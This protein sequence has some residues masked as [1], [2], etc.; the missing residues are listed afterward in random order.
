VD[1][2]IKISD[3][4]INRS[5]METM[6]NNCN[7]TSGIGKVI[8]LLL[9]I[10]SLLL[11]GNESYA[12]VSSN[13]VNASVTPGE[14]LRA[15]GSVNFTP[16]TFSV[17]APGGVST[18]EWTN[19]PINV[20]LTYTLQSTDGV[21]YKLLGATAYRAIID[22]GVT[23]L[24]FQV[25]S[26]SGVQ[27]TLT[28][29]LN[30][31][32]D[33]APAVS[34][35][36]STPLL[37]H[38]GQQ[39]QVGVQLNDAG[40]N[41]LSLRILLAANGVPAEQG[42]VLGGKNW[43]R[44]LQGQGGE[45]YIDGFDQI[46]GRIDKAAFALKL[47]L[48]ID[49]TITPGDYQLTIQAKDGKGNVMLSA[50]RATTIQGP[51]VPPTL[52][53]S[54]PTY[55]IPA[56]NVYP[57]HYQVSHLEKLAR[58]EF[59][60]VGTSGNPVTQVVT[61]ADNVYQITD[62]AYLT[63][64]AGA[65]VG[66]SVNINATV[67]D[68][69]G[70]HSATLASVTVG[71]WGE[72][73]VIVSNTASVDVDESMNFANVTLTSGSVLRHVDGNIRFNTLSIE[74]GARFESAADTLGIN[75]TLTVDGELYTA[76][77]YS[78]ADYV[79]NVIRSGAHGGNR[80]SYYAYGDFLQPQFPGIYTNNSSYIANNLHISATDISINGV[81]RTGGATGAF[82]AVLEIDSSNLTLNGA[83]ST[84]AASNASA[85]SI[86][87]N[88]SNITGSGSITADGSNG[89]N[90][91]AG[92][93]IA[94]RYDSYAG[95]N[96]PIE[97]GLTLHA[98]PGTTTSAS[99]SAGAGTVYL[100]RSDQL[101][102]ELSIDNGGRDGGV[103]SLRAIGRGTIEAVEPLVGKVDE[104]RIT[105]NHDFILP[106]PRSWDLGVKG[107]RVSLNA[108][109]PAAPLYSVIDT[110][111]EAGAINIEATRT[112]A[113]A[114]T[115]GSIQTHYINIATDQTLEFEIT[116]ANFD[117]RVHLFRDDGALD[118]TDWLAENSDNGTGTNAYLRRH[119]QA[120][121]YLLVVGPQS[122]SRYVA[123]SDTTPGWMPACDNCSYTLRIRKATTHSLLVR[124]SSD[125]SGNIGNDLIGVIRLDKFSAT[126]G[127]LVSSRGRI[128][129]DAFDLT[130][131]ASV[132]QIAEL[133]SSNVNNIGDVTFTDQSRVFVGDVVAN[134]LV[135]AAANLKIYGNLNVAGDL[136]IQN[137]TN[138]KVTQLAQDA[139]QVTGNTLLQD[140]ELSL[141]SHSLSTFNG[142]LT[143]A[144]PNQP[145]VLT[146]P[147]PDA[148]A[149]KLY[150][151]WLDVAGQV[152]IDANS[153]IDV[154]GKGYPGGKTVGFRNYLNSAS[155][156]GEGGVYSYGT[157]RVSDPGY[158]DFIDPQ[159][160]G[161]AG[162]YLAGG[163][164]I[165]TL[166]AGSLLLDGRI[167][168]EGASNNSAGGSINISTGVFSGSGSIAANAGIDPTST[169]L[170]QS[171]AGGRI[172][173]AAQIDNF[174]ASGTYSAAAG[175]ITVPDH[176]AQGAPGT[177]YLRTTGKP[178]GYLK[179]DTQRN[180]SPQVTDR[181]TVLRSVGSQ[182]ISS[183][184]SLG[185]DNWRINVAGSP[186]SAAADSV[187]GQ[188][189]IGLQVDLDAADESG[190]HYR[191][192]SNDIN[193]ITLNTIDDLSIYS[194]RTL[195]GV[196]NIEQLS[197]IGGAHLYTTDRL[198]IENST[199]LQLDA[200][201]H[202]TVGQ[203]N[204]AAATVLLG[205]SGMGTLEFV[206]PFSANDLNLVGAYVFSGGL[207]VANS[208]NLSASAVLTVS[209]LD[210]DQLILN[211]GSVTADTL[212]TRILTANGGSIDARNLNVTDATA[213]NVILNI[214]NINA[215][216]NF[217]LGNG[218][219]I[220]VPDATD[221]RF[222]ALYINVA[223]TLDVGLGAMIDLNGKGY[224]DNY[225]YN[226]NFIQFHTWNGGIAHSCHG[227]RGVSE[228]FYAISANNINANGP[229]NCSYGET[230]GA[231]YAGLANYMGDPGGGNG[232]IIA[233][234]LI[235]NGRVRANGVL[236]PGL[237]GSYAY[238]G[239][240]GGGLNIEAANLS[241]NGSIEAR[242]DEDA[243]VAIN[244]Y[245]GWYW[246][247]A[248]GRISVST[249]LSNSFGG[250]YD[251][252]AGI[253]GTSGATGGSG[254][255]LLR[256]QNNAQGQLVIDNF[257][258]QDSIAPSGLDIKDVPTVIAGVGRHT[259]AAA[260]AQGAGLWR[261]RINPDKMDN[262]R[263]AGSISTP[264]AVSLQKFSLQADYDVSL[265]AD[266]AYH[267]TIMLF[268]DD[269]DLDASDLI[270][271]ARS[272]TYT[273]GIIN[274]HL[275]AGNYLLAIASGQATLDEVLQ[276]NNADN[277]HHVAR[278]PSQPDATGSIAYTLQ[279]NPTLDPTWQITAEQSIAGH[280]V[281][282][283]ADDPNSPL[284]PI[285]SNLA[286]SIVVDT[287]NT[288]ADLSVLVGKDLIGVH[289]LE[290]LQV[291]GGTFADF[292]NDRLVLLQP[293]QSAVA[294]NATLA[295][296]DLD[297]ATLEALLSTSSG[298]LIVN[299]NLNL[300]VLTLSNA[301]LEVKGQLN[302]TGD[303]NVGVN[304]HLT[305][306]TLTANNVLIDNATLIG[307]RIT[308]S[309]N[310]DV[311]N[312]GLLT[313][314]DAWVDSNNS[315][316][317]RIYALDLNVSGTISIDALSSIN[318]D[319][320]GYPDYYRG[321]EFIKDNSNY[322]CHAGKRSDATQ[323]C[324][325]GRY[326]QAAF[327]GS[328]G[329]YAN[330]GGGTVSLHAAALNNDGRI[331]ANGT[332]TSRGGAGGGI[333]L[334]ITDLSGSGVIEASGA[335]GAGGG[336][337]SVIVAGIDNFSGSYRAAS[338]I[339]TSSIGGAGTVYLQ[340]PAF[341]VGNLIVD[342]LGKITADGST[343]LRHMGRHT[344]SNAVRN[345]NSLTLTVADSPN[346][347]PSDVQL[348][349][350]F[351]GMSVDLDARDQSGTLYKILSNG[352]DTLVIDDSAANII[353]PTTLIG[354]DLIGV[355]VF[356][357]LQVLN[358]ASVDFG[359]DRVVINHPVNTDFA[360][361][362]HI[363]MG[364]INGAA[365]NA[366]LQQLGA[367]TTLE[368]QG[369]VTLNSLN[370]FSG[371]LIVQGDMTVASGLTLSDLAT[372]SIL[373]RLSVNGDIAIA[374]SAVLI[375]PDAQASNLLIDG[376]TMEASILNISNN[377]TLLS[378]TDTGVL[379]VPAA[380]LEP[381]YVYPL[382]ITVGNALI[383]NTGARIDVNG[384]GYPG[385]LAANNNLYFV[386][387][388]GPDFNYQD[389]VSCH[390]GQIAIPVNNW[391]CITYGRLEQARFA[392]SAGSYL[393]ATLN[394]NGGG[395]IHIHANSLNNSGSISADG[396]ISDYGGAGGSIHI[397]VNDLLGSGV[398]SANGGAPQTTYTSGGG[399][400]RISLYLPDVF[401]NGFDMNNLQAQGGM[402]S[403]SANIAGA[404]TIYLKYANQSH[405]HL[406]LDN[407]GNS[408]SL[409]STPARK[410][411]I[412]GSAGCV[413]DSVTNHLDGTYT[414]HLGA[415]NALHL[416]Q[417]GVIT[418]SG[419]DSVLQHHFSLNA[420]RK[421]KIEITDG[422][423]NSD[424][425]LFEDMGTSLRYISYDISS[426]NG[427]LSRIA[428]TS[429]QAGNYVVA[430]SG[431]YTQQYQAASG[432]KSNNSQFGAY[433][434]QIDTQ[435]DSWHASDPVYGWGLDGLSVSLDATN[436][437]ASLYPIVSNDEESITVSSLAEDLSTLVTPGITTLFGV[438]QF[439]TLTVRGGAQLD[440]GADRVIVID[441]IN[442]LV[443][444]GSAVTADPDST[445]P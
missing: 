355:Q 348:V 35:S 313:L 312:G 93:R 266:T 82:G 352:A 29:P 255:V 436:P 70:N 303:L 189:L 69:N 279:I 53:L 405:G 349:W 253:S 178:I 111:A 397:A 127:T 310:L 22:S 382:D 412:C 359:G 258:R 126:P 391:Q 125:I 152:N 283:H 260:T 402:F 325:Y 272:G 322:S 202:L 350:G 184:E 172:S 271:N 342:N 290:S 192:E 262:I 386:Q 104:Y 398:F 245:A 221:E 162:N 146:V 224:T 223:G 431:T 239:P 175:R 299:A 132:S 88:S 234:D 329:G 327:A 55:R 205:A 62:T 59:V 331:G 142:D 228:Q 42:I 323:D 257:N 346:W 2:F 302:L 168:A 171:A 343:P 159:F 74:S 354:Q 105:L 388:G 432:S 278:D 190:K 395:S 370:Q 374:A 3:Y 51:V 33:P 425:Y 19:Q 199:T 438:H 144:S 422:V 287:G 251:A 249:T 244:Y 112:L 77:H 110:T 364:E 442:S 41:I 409:Y 284:Y 49:K 8:F 86:N 1:N 75:G 83:I 47:A 366:L 149:Q 84:N 173:V 444:S 360:N 78:A 150:P 423:F 396:N 52:S 217:T 259:I 137:T 378:S 367:A 230:R 369:S 39:T 336:R 94:I 424:M 7:K 28:I 218:A 31:I 81:V 197:V 133:Y 232:E 317:K 392:G 371:N 147:Q 34:F 400:G 24:Q 90:N 390:A 321:P 241:G 225:R 288:G 403:G 415:N 191:I 376:G 57:L 263:L 363:R 319:G 242:G 435:D 356:D 335:M 154:S 161:A 357:R 96:L 117:S 23:E 203:M 186:W 328:G 414:L 12:A 353:D 65:N 297:K 118:N 233:G 427:S 158:G 339:N 56:G 20:P 153:R 60:Q 207:T 163:G 270:G 330:A 196:I 275:L 73:S 308:T 229:D 247:G 176:F 166:K 379:T 177:V 45:A 338:G 365:L 445:L 13:I 157:N 429:L 100:K 296:G 185:N 99:N 209:H 407:G 264:Q 410:V 426:G 333:H 227:G 413:I 164:G 119:L 399:G 183:I 54:V 139:L 50:P 274:T 14:L 121:R 187:D 337:I 9:L 179:I 15:N 420:A 309:G 215:S 300:D 340:T 306:T 289:T 295:V 301:R 204:A 109:D 417:S 377:I 200:L 36:N 216:G 235:I 148:A 130:V 293:L 282:L 294:A 95:G 180:A 156:G 136:T 361:A 167:E 107:L 419:A 198:V 58:I 165:L 91:G 66:D 92:G 131:P 315:L 326:Q 246:S 11:G 256:D 120:G 101:Y 211:G 236:R 406:L 208:L 212:N 134:N 291:R 381:R 85:G 46:T 155:H 307:E 123:I 4:V 169:N 97:Q 116:Q 304:T 285:V 140:A 72:R 250:I 44:H 380:T 240:A 394:G 265:S 87:I 6:A 344:I 298:K 71:N 273:N 277:S 311:V 347:R 151:L 115:P 10:P 113:A 267:Y 38:K 332:G 237:Y 98:Y 40:K 318:L 439:E 106:V 201:S 79:E 385:R 76:M 25:T 383:V 219:S 210:S 114:H 443:E 393:N 316:N 320:K 103:T 231:H 174:S 141:N 362:G 418:Q 408:A 61:L 64:P 138:S 108:D 372:L 102:G 292:G 248:G 389:S 37:L 135:L 276:G 280:L 160:A 437:A 428:S 89:A 341:P 252:G 286:E 269:A 63:L 170:Y 194:G 16:I 243:S 18:V 21:T 368:L 324:T 345:G 195:I 222:S 401:A 68:V 124:S 373:G 27:S 32:A 67:Y 281:S 440:F 416:K 404:G 220:I 122:M 48:S 206:A 5:V 430:V 384:K 254:T 238:E 434:L 387:N 226:N 213:D 128:H 129:G 351:D 30:F 314:P 411:N 214:E 358:G 80:L 268:R 143:L 305:A 193:S 145:S 182:V 334:A 188:G 26:N 433:T 181:R 441:T 43:G 17:D 375:A 421:V 261:I